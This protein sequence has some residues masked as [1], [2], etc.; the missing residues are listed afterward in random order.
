PHLG[1]GGVDGG[2]AGGVADDEI[3]T[4]SGQGQSDTAPEATAATGD[5]SS[6]HGRLLMAGSTGLCS[7]P[8]P[9][10]LCSRRHQPAKRGDMALVGGP[11][12]L[13]MPLQA[14]H[15]GRL[16]RFDD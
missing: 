10:D 9:P 2:L 5:D 15:S 4:G 16:D 8:V 6:T 12:A 3:E 7:W 1:G 11:E 13:G 14:E